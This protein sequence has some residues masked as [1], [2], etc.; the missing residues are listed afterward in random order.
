MET[1]RFIEQSLNQVHQ[2]LLGSLEGLVQEDLSWRPAP[3]AN[4]IGDILWHLVRS[5]DRAGRLAIGLG[6]ELW[7][8][9][10]WHKRFGY[11]REAPPGND[12]QALNAF[13]TPPN[14]ETL[15]A[16]MDA[17]HEDTIRNLVTLSPKDLDRIPNPA[18]P[19]R[20][21]ASYFR[22]MITHKNNHHGQVD[23]IRGLM[24]PGWD[25]PPGRGIV[26]R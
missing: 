24:Q 9:Q 21:I 13:S 7:D 26:Q 2:R 6:P 8:A 12:Y 19:Q 20:D 14:I 5:E 1:L 11:P 10:E 22:H 15:I 23:F 16:Y 18:H 3:H 25:L 17:V 4:T